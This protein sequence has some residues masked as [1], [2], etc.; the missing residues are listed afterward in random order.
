MIDESVA[1]RPWIPLAARLTHVDDE[2]KV[3]LR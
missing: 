3:A 2:D 1:L